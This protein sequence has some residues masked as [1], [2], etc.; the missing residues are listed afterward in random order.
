MIAGC[1][2]WLSVTRDLL[3]AHDTRFAV[4]EKKWIIFDLEEYI[5]SD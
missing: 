1:D 5:H 3:Q 4:I 2:A